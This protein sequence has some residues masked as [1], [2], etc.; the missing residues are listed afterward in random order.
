MKCHSIKF[1]VTFDASTLKEKSSNLENV[2][3]ISALYFKITKL[4]INSQM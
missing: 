1:F 4:L 2:Y 3:A